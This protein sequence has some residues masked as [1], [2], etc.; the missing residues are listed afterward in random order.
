MSKTRFD[1]EDELMKCW[2]ITDDIAAVSDI[3]VDTEMDD[4]DKDKFLNILI[5]MK[6]LYDHKFQEAYNTMDALIRQRELI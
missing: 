3:V 1:L 5:G 2:H 4:R 6:Q